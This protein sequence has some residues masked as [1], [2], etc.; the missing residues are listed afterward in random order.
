MPSATSV[1]SSN[2]P[3]R[4][5]FLRELVIETDGISTLGIYAQRLQKFS[6]SHELICYERQVFYVIWARNDQVIDAEPEW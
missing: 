2:L 1:R 6:E 4:L 3:S 5:K